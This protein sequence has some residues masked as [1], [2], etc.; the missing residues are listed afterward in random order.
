MVEGQVKEIS[1]WVGIT[2]LEERYQ[3][4]QRTIWRWQREKGFPRPRLKTRQSLWA[5]EDVV[6]WEN[7][8]QAA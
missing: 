8:L 5:W 4:A 1:K 2:V 6:Q 7:N 3:C